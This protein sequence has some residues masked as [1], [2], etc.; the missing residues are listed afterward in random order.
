MHVVT[1]MNGPLYVPTRVNYMETLTMAKTSNK[2]NLIRTD[3]DAA[4]EH[5][6]TVDDY[7]GDSCDLLHLKEMLKT[8]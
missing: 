8:T 4:G 3:Q 1:V 5:T 6:G 2:T 7:L